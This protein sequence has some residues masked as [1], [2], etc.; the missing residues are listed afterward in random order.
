M[1]SGGLL[2]AA[3]LA[4]PRCHMEGTVT[5]AARWIEL[6]A[7]FGLLPV[8]LAAFAPGLSLPVLF[9]IAWVCLAVL[10][11]DPTFQRDELWRRERLWLLFTVGLGRWFVTGV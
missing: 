10:W 2:F 1:N 3:C 4:S 11:R 8:A 6:A 5:R 9:V 7:L